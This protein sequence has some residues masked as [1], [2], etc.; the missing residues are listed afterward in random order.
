MAGNTIATHTATLIRSMTTG[1]LIRQVGV[2]V[3]GVF[4]GI[5]NGAY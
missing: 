1:F 4:A 5:K 3:D 2:V